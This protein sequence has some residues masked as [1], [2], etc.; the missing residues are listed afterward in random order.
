MTVDA[1]ELCYLSA[2]ELRQLYAARALSPVEVTRAVLERTERLN[3]SLT[4][5]V[6]VTADLAMDQARAAERAYA[7]GRTDQPLLGV[8][9][10]LKDL[11][12]TKGIRTTRG[13]LLWKDWVP[14]ADAPIVE[15]LY[16]AGG[17]LIGKT[18]TP[19]FGWKG[20]SGNRVVGPSHNPWQ[21]GRT[22]GGS[23]GGAAAAVAAG[24]GPLSQGT[25]GAGSVR[26]PA[27]FCGI[28]GLKPSFGLV[29]Y[30]PPSN[31]ESLAHTGPMTRTVRD[32]A[33]FLNVMAGFDWRDRLSIDPPVDD[34]VAACEGGVEGMRVAWSRDLGYAVVDP[35]V[36]DLAEQAAQVFSELGCHVEEVDLGWEDPFPMLD[37]IWSAGMAAAFR[38]NFDAVREQLDPGLARVIEAGRQLSGLELASAMARRALFADQ[39]RR[40]LEPYDFLLTPTLPTTAFEAGADHPGQIMGKPTEYLSWTAYT[41]PFNLTGQPAATV[42]CGHTKEGLPVG[43]Q[44]VGRLREDATVFRAAAA[45]EAARPWADNRPPL[46]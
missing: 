46:D 26:I 23:S 18:N 14:G 36:A 7:A 37:A 22:A 35:E 5:Y 30:Y 25:D 43:L 10:S 34:F 39:V 15:R 11:T 16:A 21:H 12:A 40:D 28:F 1:T 8:P 2:M 19:E 38:D 17:V 4:A 20:D 44:I 6:T 13:S 27:A 42:P 9:F 29:P 24:L 32:A 41:Y 3:P 31:V 45:F 33:L